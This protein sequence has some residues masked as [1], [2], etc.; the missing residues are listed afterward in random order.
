MKQD[1]DQKFT[2]LKEKAAKNR[3]RFKWQD[4]ALGIIEELGLPRF[5]QT[6]K[7]KRPLDVRGILMRHAKEDLAIFQRRFGIV[8]EQGF[9][10]DEAVLYYLGIVEKE[11]ELTPDE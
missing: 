1:L 3:I 10:G 9:R 11:H 8:K 4:T 6:K 5:V 2:K 7:R